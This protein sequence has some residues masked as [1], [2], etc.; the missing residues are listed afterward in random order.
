MDKLLDVQ[1]LKVHFNIKRGF[2]EDIFSKD[3]VVVKAV[4]GVDRKSVV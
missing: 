2:I 4:D 1:D 3:Q